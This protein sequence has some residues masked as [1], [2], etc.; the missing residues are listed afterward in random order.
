MSNTFS[1]NDWREFPKYLPTSPG[2]YLVI[3]SCGDREWTSIKLWNR[4]QVHQLDS[5]YP[6]NPTPV[7]VGHEQVLDYDQWH[8]GMEF[9]DTKVLA[10]A[11]IPE[12]PNR[13]LLDYWKGSS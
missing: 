6:N 3:L 11:K 2:K 10:W 1:N 5:S 13:L 4:Q 8:L 9:E 7:F 12:M